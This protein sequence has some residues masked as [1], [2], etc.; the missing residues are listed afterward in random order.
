MV[1]KG[2]ADDRITPVGYGE[3]F[4]LNRCTDGIECTDDEHRYNRRTEFKILAGP[5]SI[6]IEETIVPETNEKPKG[7]KPGGKQ[8]VRPVFFYQN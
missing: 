4:I 8:S 6:E 1:A 7:Q 2:I 5:T 3:Q